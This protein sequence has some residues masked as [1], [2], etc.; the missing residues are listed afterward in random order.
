MDGRTETEYIKRHESKKIFEFLAPAFTFS[1]P[2]LA[3]G[4]YSIPFAF[5]LPPGLPSSILFKRE[6]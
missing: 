2:V 1:T 3:P 5:M 6:G 4:D